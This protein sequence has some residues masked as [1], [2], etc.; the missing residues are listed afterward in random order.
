MSA[1]INFIDIW[2]EL[3]E[4]NYDSRRVAYITST[5]G[6]FNQIH[7]NMIKP[8]IPKQKVHTRMTDIGGGWYNKKVVMDYL[9]ER[10]QK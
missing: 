1:T 10:D 4:E 3:L 2:V 8:F 5:K 9:Y 7:I 6:M